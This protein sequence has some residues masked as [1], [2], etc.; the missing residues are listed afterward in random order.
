[1]LRS[2]IKKRLVVHRQYTLLGKI[3]ET[4]HKVISPLLS[5]CSDRPVLDKNLPVPEC[6]YVK[7][8]QVHR[9]NTSK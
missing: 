7:K 2:A 5:L 9:V 4:A 1:M 8:L 6:S 3:P